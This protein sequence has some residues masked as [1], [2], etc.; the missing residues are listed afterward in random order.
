M[1]SGSDGATGTSPR[2]VPFSPPDIR[3]EDIRA[4][5]D[6]LRSGWITSG[7]VGRTFEG[8]LAAATGADGALLVSSATTALETALRLLG[9]GPGDEVVTTAYTYSASAAVIAHVGAD[10]RLVDTAPGGFA[11]R[12]E[13]V[14]AAVTPR[15]KAVVT[16]DLG[17]VLFDHEALAAALAGR[18]DF[19]PAGPVQ[20]ALGRVAVVADAAH[21]LGAVLRGGR[22][23]SLA[24]LTAFS[25]HAVKNVT[26]GEGGALLWRAPDGVPAD[27]LRA[28]ARLL[29][30]HGQ[31]KDALA[32][33]RLG[34][35]EYDIAELGHKCNLPDVLA[36]LGLS[37]FRRYE[38][39]LE[40]RHAVVARYDR[41][42]DGTGITS[43]VHTGPDFRSSAHLYLALLPSSDVAARNAVIE[44]MATDGI[45]ANVH[46][47]PLPLLSAYRTLG[48]DPQDVPNAMDVYGRVVSLPLHTLLTDD[49]V[50]RVAA[51]LVRHAAGPAPAA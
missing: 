38:E 20:E 5:V 25:F 29:T 4:V 16:V 46:Y 37:Q 23:G 17:G 10:I 49:D 18:P 50:D 24:D 8:E 48:F 45:A 13:D 14:L 51:S 7:P 31:T 19:T 41:R 39:L 26:T 6:V 11:P 36:A 21:S 44:G 42:L 35:W 32:K 27:D 22:S 3:E 1:T 28:R 9:V 12:V 34:S 33:T 40:R 15:T 30:M 43:L 2:A 47:K